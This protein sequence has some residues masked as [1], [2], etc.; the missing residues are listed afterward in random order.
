MGASPVFIC[1][2]SIW[3]TLRHTICS[4]ALVASALETIHSA[5]PRDQTALRSMNVDALKANP[6]VAIEAKT[7]DLEGKDVIASIAVGTLD[8]IAPEVISS[9]EANTSRL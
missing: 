4:S 5:D 7:H 8:R 1:R 2:V 9:E 6:L 3:R